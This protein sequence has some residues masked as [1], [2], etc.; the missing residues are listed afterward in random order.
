MINQGMFPP[1][2]AI[3][4]EEFINYFDNDY[5]QQNEYENDVP[6]NIYMAIATS[7]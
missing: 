5:T 4:I 2:D 6:F 7:P 3:I 1:E